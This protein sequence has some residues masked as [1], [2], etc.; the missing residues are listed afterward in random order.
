MVA[1][2]DAQRYAIV[3][4]VIEGVRGEDVVYQVHDMVTATTWS[5]TYPTKQDAEKAIRFTWVRQ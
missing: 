3:S 2:K 1:K 5:E 4:K